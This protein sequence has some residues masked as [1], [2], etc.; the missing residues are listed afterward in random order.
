MTMPWQLREGLKRRPKGSRPPRPIAEQ[1]PQI[2]VND[3]Q[4]PRDY[5]TYTAPNISLK[6][7]QIAALRMWYEAVE[8]HHPSLHRGQN[9]PA[10]IFQIKHIK[11]GFGIRHAF[12]CATCKRPVIKLYYRHRH[13]ACR[14]CQD[15]IYASQSIDQ[16]S[17]PVLQASRIQSFLDNKSR[18]FRRTR[19]R[20][21]KKLGHKVMMAQARLGTRAAG[22]WE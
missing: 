21:E 5:R 3:L 4:I 22:L 9:G 2:S 16:Y 14:R 7:P 8:F 18:L 20:L 13:L 15:A 11:T 6:Y 10:Q 19:E 12:I 1:L 17:R